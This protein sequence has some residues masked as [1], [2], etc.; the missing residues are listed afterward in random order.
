M[1]GVVQ[2][3]DHVAAVLS[4]EFV[5]ATV[6][7]TDEPESVRVEPQRRQHEQ[8]VDHAVGEQSHRLLVVLRGD[9]FHG[10]EGGPV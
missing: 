7:L 10:P 6:V 1:A 5:E 2:G 8:F 4:Y 9:L 3:A